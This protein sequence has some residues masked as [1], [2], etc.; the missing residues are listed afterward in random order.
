MNN[1]VVQNHS[2]EKEELLELMPELD[3]LPDGFVLEIESTYTPG[4]PDVWYLR[5]GDPGYPGDPPEIE[6]R[7]LNKG[8][9]KELMFKIEEDQKVRKYV[10][11]VVVNAMDSY[12][13][14]PD[15]DL[16]YD[17]QIDFE[18]EED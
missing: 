4:T 5:N 8:M 13:D 10:D 12:D 9:D 15:P 2:I 7:I 17:S 1:K 11:E 16:D 14:G 18:D 3:S 6:W